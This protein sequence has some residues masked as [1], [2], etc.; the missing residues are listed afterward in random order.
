[1]N[2]SALDEVLSAIDPT[3][4]GPFFVAKLFKARDE[5]AAL[6]AATPSTQAEEAARMTVCS[7]CGKVSDCGSSDLDAKRKVANEHILVCDKRPE[8]QLLDELCHLHN[9]L[10]RA[11]VCAHETC[12]PNVTDFNECTSAMCTENREVL[13]MERLA[14]TP[15]VAAPTEDK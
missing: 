6:K 9:L 13:A 15:S 7:Y 12:S 4:V 3:V 11:A 10:R 14:A 1:M 2:T 5:L 8:K